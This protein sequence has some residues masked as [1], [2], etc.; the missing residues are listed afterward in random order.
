MQEPPPGA[1][2]GDG[3]VEDGEGER[4]K[5]P[6]PSGIA[7]GAGGGSGS[8]SAA[9][10]GDAAGGVPGAAAVGEEQMMMQDVAAMTGEGEA[11]ACLCCGLVPAT[12]ASS[13]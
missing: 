10:V 9:A 4:G 3:E 6:E 2:E 5:T 13:H 7:A 1:A 12:P 11:V 8:L